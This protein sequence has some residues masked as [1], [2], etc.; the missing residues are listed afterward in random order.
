MSAVDYQKYGFQAQENAALPRS[1]GTDYQKYGF[2]PKNQQV[3]SSQYGQ[4]IFGSKALGESVQNINTIMG[5]LVHGPLEVASN[6]INAPQDV[7]R[8]L[9]MNVG[10]PWTQ[11]PIPAFADPN[12]LSFKVPSFVSQ[13]LTPLGSANLAVKGL[14]ARTAV[15]GLMGFL[16]TGGDVSSRLMGGALSAALPLG[17]EGIKSGKKIAN[18]LTGNNIQNAADNI[19]NTIAKGKTHAG[20]NTENIQNIKSNYNALHAEYQNAFGNLENT[21][22]ERGYATS[23]NP[24]KQIL[25]GALPEKFINVSRGTS[26]ILDEASK[27]HSVIKRTLKDFNNSPTFSNAK[28]LQSQLGVLSNDFYTKTTGLKS[29][30]RET[31]ELLRNAKESVLN[32]IGNT[33]LQKGD[34]DLFQNFK[35]LRTNYGTKLAPYTDIPGIRNIINNKAYPD[36]VIKVLDEEGY[37]N[38]GDVVRGDLLKNPIQRQT[39]IAQAL[40]PGATKRGNIW[41][42]KPEKFL[43]TFNKLPTNIH[44]FIDPKLHENI[45]ALSQMSEHFNIL[46]RRLKIGALATGAIAATRMGKSE[47]NQ[48]I[49][50]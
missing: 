48:F 4:P 23:G 36:N 32:D 44:Q 18:Y 33:M 16:G 28:N 35:T 30:N 14:G 41:K 50:E 29:V 9:G 1:V 13:V 31:G 37:K 26:D 45:N 27:K 19:Y 2:Q 17:I 3:S 12:S 38:A 15:S 6:I 34:Q 25:T 11:A 21:A 20:M 39:V 7:A 5:G 43:D 42:T 49:N 10:K 40:R 47:I 24:S 8:S 22:I 46:K